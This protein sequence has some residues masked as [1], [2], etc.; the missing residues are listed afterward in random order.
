MSDSNYEPQ[1]PQPS[2]RRFRPD[3]SPETC[4]NRT[5]ITDLSQSG[6]ARPAVKLPSDYEI[7]IIPPQSLPDET[8]THP[9]V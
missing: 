1:R 7:T 6:T 8:A 2:A 5:E 9:S 4:G 3:M